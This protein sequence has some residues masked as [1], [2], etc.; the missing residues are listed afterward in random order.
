MLWTLLQGVISYALTVKQKIILLLRKQ[1]NTLNYSSRFKKKIQFHNVQWLF[2]HPN[3][4][5]VHRL[6]HC[7]Q[8]I[9]FDLAQQN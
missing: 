3:N 8:I 4:L 2:Y 5:E 7:F 9:L 1:Q 6:Q